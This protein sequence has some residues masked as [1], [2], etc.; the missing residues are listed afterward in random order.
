DADRP[1]PAL[2]TARDEERRG[3]LGQG[4]VRAEVTG[5]DR[6]L[7]AGFGKACPREAADRLEHREAGIGSRLD[8]SDEAVVDQIGQTVDDVAADR[9]VGAAHRLGFVDPAATSKDREAGEQ[10]SLRLL[11]EVIAPGDRRVERLLALGKVTG[12]AA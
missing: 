5:G 8:P 11:E 6:P 1:G 2:L 3:A 12:R 9:L 4:G 10:P 7:V